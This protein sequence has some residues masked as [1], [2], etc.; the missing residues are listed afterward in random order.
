MRNLQLLLKWGYWTSNP[1]IFVKLVYF[2]IVTRKP[3]IMFWKCERFPA[4]HKLFSVSMKMFITH[5]EDHQYPSDISALSVRICSAHKKNHKYLWDICT[6]P[7]RIS[8]VPMGKFI[9]S[10][11]EYHHYP[12]LSEYHA[13][14]DMPHR[15]WLSS[16]QVLHFSI[17]WVSIRNI[18]P[19]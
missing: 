3:L 14:V 16:S 1:E 9:S 8:S 15:Y 4:N 17:V 10:C 18:H 11:E 2:L 6:V 12:Q 19:V 13:T 7:W 5:E